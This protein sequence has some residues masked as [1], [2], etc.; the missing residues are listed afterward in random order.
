M[1]ARV[2][3]RML[4]PLPYIIGAVGFDLTPGL[5]IEQLSERTAFC[6]IEILLH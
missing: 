5:K 3:T 2:S 1:P 4:A 6:K